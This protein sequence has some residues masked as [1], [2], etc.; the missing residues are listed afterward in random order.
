METRGRPPEYNTP[1][2][3]RIAV[4]GY[5]DDCDKEGV[6]PDLAG[7]KR[8][9]KLSK[10]DIDEMTSDNNPACEDYRYIFECARDRRESWLARRM[11]TEPKAANGCM[12]ALKQE[13]NGGY[14][15]KSADKAPQTIK[16]VM[17]GVGGMDAFK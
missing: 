17:D 8:A 7:M 1:Q 4:E 5:F 11:V 15:D 12:N 3:L 2:K 16:I 9:L 10:R 13:Q 14:M 6:F